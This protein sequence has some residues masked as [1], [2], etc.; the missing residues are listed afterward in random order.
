MTKKATYNYI[1][2][3]LANSTGISKRKS[4]EF[5]KGLISIVKD[6]LKSSGKASITNFGSF[7]VKN[8][9]EREGINPQTGETILIPSH[10]KVSFRPYIAL[11]KRVNKPYNH[12]ES[13]LIDSGKVQIKNVPRGPFSPKRKSQSATIVLSAL[14]FLVISL[15]VAWYFIENSSEATDSSEAL[16]ETTQTPV[17]DTQSKAEI[18]ESESESLT[19]VKTDENE[20]KAEIASAQDETDETEAKTETASATDETV[21][22]NH[23]NVQNNEWFWVIS[24]K[25]Y[26]K[27]EWWPL[28]YQENYQQHEDPDDLVVSK[29]LAIPE[30]KGTIDNPHK[31]DYQQLAKATQMVSEA[32]LKFNK[33]DKAKEYERFAKQYEKLGL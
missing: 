21:N 13:Q 25:V 22:S 32:Y 3:A 10:K 17:E 27:S 12:L 18:T 14:I 30:L 20:S 28:I 6:D 33:P 9:A 8:V 24:K 31:N 2:E 7:K 1:V 5:A 15:T 19:D 26:G 23:Y 16:I 29:G 11:K 4:D